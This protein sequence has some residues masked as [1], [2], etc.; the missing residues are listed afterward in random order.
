MLQ[1]CEAEVV[2]LD[3]MMQGVAYLQDDNFLQKT[4]RNIK[5][6]SREEKIEK[7]IESLRELFTRMYL[8]YNHQSLRASSGFL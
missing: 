1:S 2:E 5:V 7:H 6:I 4:K 8:W 3:Q